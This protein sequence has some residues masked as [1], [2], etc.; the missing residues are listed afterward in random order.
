[1]NL[2][3]REDLEFMRE[4]REASDAYLCM[5]LRFQ[6]CEQWKAVA[7]KREIRQRQERESA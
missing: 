6:C 2:K 3:N 5:L 7:V 1:M 4:V